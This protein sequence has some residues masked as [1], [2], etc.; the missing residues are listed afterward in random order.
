CPMH[1]VLRKIRTLRPRALRRRLL[2]RKDAHLTTHRGRR[3]ADSHGR[4][5]ESMKMMRLSVGM[6]ALVLALGLAA[7]PAGAKRASAGG[8]PGPTT[9]ATGLANPRGLAFAPNGT[10]YVAEAGSGGPVDVGG[11]TFVGFT[12]QID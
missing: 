10:L 4:D 12:S 9:V 1:R 7:V 11:G 6:A 5:D 8:D 2:V 3:R